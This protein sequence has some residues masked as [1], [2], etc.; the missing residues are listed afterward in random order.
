MAYGTAYTHR[1]T[2]YSLKAMLDNAISLAIQRNAMS[3]SININEDVDPA[4]TNGLKTV[5]VKLGYKVK[6]E[7]KMGIFEPGIVRPP[8]TTLTLFW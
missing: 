4:I 5:L 6:C 1:A 8:Q 3:A 2:I 7:R